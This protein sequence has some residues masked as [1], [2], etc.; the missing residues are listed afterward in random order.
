MQG[1]AMLKVISRVVLVWLCGIGTSNFVIAAAS[2]ES[3]N[4]ILITIN[5]LRA[6]HVSAMGY[7]RN[8]TV[9][10]DKFAED[11]VMFTRAFATSS[12]QMPATGSLFTSLYPSEHGATHI[13][14]QLGTFPTLAG[15]LSAN[16]YYTAGFCCNPRLSYDYG[17]GQGFDFYDDF[18]VRLLLEQHLFGNEDSVN[19]NQSRTND[20]I[21]DAVTRWLENNVHAPFFLYV[22]YY[23]N[24]WDYLPPE[25]YRSYFSSDYQGDIDGTNIARE[26][27]YSNRPSDEDVEQIIALYDGQVKQT[28]QDMGDLLDIFK[29]H[30]L[31]ENSIIIIKGEHGEQFYEHGNTSHHG[32]YEELIHVPLA[33]SLPSGNYNSSIDALVS[34]V[35]ILPTILDYVGVPV[36]ENAKG[37]SIRP[38]IE[39]RS[40]SVRDFVFVEYT[41]RAITIEDSFGARF[42]RYKFVYEQG[43]IFAYDLLTDPGEQ[44][45]IYKASFDKE[46]HALFD[47]VKDLLWSHAGQSAQ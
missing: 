34:G 25:P 28:D 43:D 24:H 40:E 39:G 14:Y 5:T 38:L 37:K 31:F 4:V 46:M 6:D 41:G 45:R 21:N 26:P 44:E 12:W 16:G 47:R 33:I 17:F 3:A 18:S 13:D 2:E 19:I 32:I 20:L 42:A 11:N 30:G 27:L 23:D 35:D 36:P 1:K 8:T 9:H 10:F 22:H 7:H 29:M 15:I